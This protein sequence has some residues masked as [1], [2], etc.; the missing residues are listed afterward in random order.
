MT[1]D[2]LEAASATT[3]STSAQQPSILILGESSTAE[4]VQDSLERDVGSRVRVWTHTGA[5]EALAVQPPST[6]LVLVLLLGQQ[7]GAR[8]LPTQ[9]RAILDWQG[10]A[11]AA[12]LVR[13]PGELPA[14]TRAALWHLG[15]ADRNFAQPLDGTDLLDAVA[16][17][18]RNGR[19]QR[20]L[21][22][23]SALSRLLVDAGTLRE[24]AQRSLHA[25]HARQLP[26][27]GGIFCYVG[28]VTERTS[29]AD[30]RPKL[31]AG[32]GCH[33]LHACPTLEHLR[34][35]AATDDGQLLT[36][37]AQ[38][39]RYHHERFDGKGYPQGLA[40]E[41]IP[42]AARIVALVDV[43]DALTSARPYKLPWPHQQAVDFIRKES[44]CH[45]D[46]KVV[47]AFLRLDTVK[48]SARHIEWSEAMSVGHATLD[49]DHQRLIE[50]IN[51]LWVA[52][53]LGN[54]QIIEFVLDDLVNYTE[55]HFAREEELLEQAGFADLERH[56]RIHLGICSRLEEI[57]WEYFQGIR[58]ELRSSL[59]EFVT[60]WLNKHILEEDMQYSGYLAVAA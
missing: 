49:F 48:K 41:D 60:V 46:P 27:R 20:A 54:R 37:A 51:R 3:I 24:L 5:W 59:L 45:F 6:D 55:F 33:T 13:C 14:D 50:I 44:G 10:H 21:A 32:T 28:K 2:Q 40:G 58:D 56:K 36:M 39:A 26:V 34:D 29:L 53:S 35:G 25:V 11:A 31:I 17:A 15:V 12:I 18:L 47:D 23:M 1:F 8:E 43:Y 9:V 16:V 30:L 7:D 4:V 57:H 22:D 38:I 52:D 19:R 42:L